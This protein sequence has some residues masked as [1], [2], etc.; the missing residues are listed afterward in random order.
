MVKRMTTLHSIYKDIII[1]VLGSTATGKSKLG[2]ELAKVFNGEII[3]AD[4]MQVYKGLDVVTNKVTANEME[5][6]PHHMIDIISPPLEFSV[7]QFRNKA[8]S[9]IDSIVKRKKVPIIVGG[10]NYYVESLLWNFSLEQTWDQEGNNE[11][12]LNETDLKFQ[13]KYNGY[14][15]EA[16]FNTLKIVDPERA[17]QL[18]PNNKRKV[19]RSLEVFEKFGKKH[20][21][22]LKLQKTEDGSS[23]WS[24]PMRFPNSIVFWLT[25]EQK[26]LE[27]RISERVDKM[28]DKGL[29]NE[30]RLFYEAYKLAFEQFDLHHK[31][32]Y[33]ESI[34]QAIGFKEFQNL[35]R[36]EGND[37]DIKFQLLSSSL[38]AL[39][40]VTI[41]YSKKQKTWIKN[42][43]LTRPNS[44]SPNIFE[45]DTTDL[46][47]WN[48]NVLSKALSICASIFKNEEILFKPLE[49]ILP[50]KNVLAKHICNVCDN[51]V[52]IGDEVWQKHLH[53][54]KHKK[55][56]KSYNKLT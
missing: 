51:R 1:V 47:R 12:Q 52:I 13:E 19:L 17:E 43:F 41:R 54:R 39:K 9:I 23:Q 45:L 31:P 35:L 37:S 56:V 30:I 55:K 40:R 29:V 2:I 25:C 33:E 7:V 44:N 48:D 8:L 46:N 49:K 6:I 36:Y 5:E 20:S 26:I 16:L 4:S 3:S 22:L 11:E 53:S 14:T 15:D 34:F 28:V 21:E 18:H 10:T 38:D 32:L 50:Q 27:R 42:R 24:G